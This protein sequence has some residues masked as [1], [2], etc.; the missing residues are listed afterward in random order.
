LRR[1]GVGQALAQRVRIVQACTELGATNLRR[2]LERRAFTSAGEL[3]AEI[4]AYIAETNVDPKPFV[5]QD[6][7]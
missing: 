1:R 7:R 2:R 4:D 3:E 5:D 6:R